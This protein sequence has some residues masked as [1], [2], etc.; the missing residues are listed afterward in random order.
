MDFLKCRIDFVL[1]SSEEKPT[2]DLKDGS[3]AYEVDT[4][5]LFIFYKGTW[6]EQ[7]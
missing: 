7:E 2:E 3:T 4:C 5:K 1:L 6:Y